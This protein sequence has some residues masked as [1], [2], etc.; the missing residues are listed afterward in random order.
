MSWESAP[1][2]VLAHSLAHPADHSAHVVDMVADLPHDVG[3]DALRGSVLLRGVRGPPNRS[4][5]GIV[6]VVRDG[7]LISGG[8]G[9]VP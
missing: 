4:P 6:T 1:D 9:V 5:S 8:S 3:T 7:V 2:E